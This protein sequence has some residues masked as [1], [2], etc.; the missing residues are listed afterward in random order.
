MISPGSKWCRSEPVFHVPG[1]LFNNQFKSRN[2][3]GD[4]FTGLKRATSVIQAITVTEYYCT[5]TYQ[6]VVL[7]FPNGGDPKAVAEAMAGFRQAHQAEQLDLSEV[8][9]SQRADYRFGLRRFAK[10]LYGTNHIEITYSIDYEAVDIRKLSPSPRGIVLLLLYLALDD[11][12]DRPLIIDQSEQNLDP[13]PIFDELIELFILAK[14]VRQ[15]IMVTPNANLVV[16]RHADQVIV[17]LAG[18]HTPGKLPLICYLSGGLE[19]AEM[20]KHVCD[21][22][23]GGERAL[24]GRARRLRVR[25]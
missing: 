15:V 6:D 18:T 16:N 7:V 2:A 23:E 17:A 10:W 1:I 3:G 24:K 4:Y 12:D 20:R 13:K 25:L 5:D 21:I 19:N 22:L 11:N 14:N 9:R 8:P